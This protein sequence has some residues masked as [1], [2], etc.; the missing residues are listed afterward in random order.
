[1]PLRNPCLPSRGG[2]HPALLNFLDD[3]RSG[4]RRPAPSALSVSPRPPPFMIALLRR[5]AALCYAP[6][7]PLPPHPWERVM[8]GGGRGI[9]KRSAGPAELGAGQ[10]PWRRCPR[11]RR[12]PGAA[13]RRSCSGGPRT[14]RSKVRAGPRRRRDS[15]RRRDARLRRSGGW[16]P[17]GARGGLRDPSRPRDSDSLGQ[18]PRR[19]VSAR[20]TLLVAPSTRLDGG[21]G[22]GGGGKELIAPRGGFVVGRGGVVRTSP[23]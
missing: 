21:V 5:R 1:M 3:R 9:R 18:Y 7:H 2:R 16:P 13:A 22:L 12:I 10:D 17:G 4:P 19:T 8:G 23:N 6:L 15:G 11:C 20:T 14:L